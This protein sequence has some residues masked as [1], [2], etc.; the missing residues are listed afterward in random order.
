MTHTGSTHA[1][2]NSKTPSM[3]AVEL[4]YTWELTCPDTLLSLVNHTDNLEQE[5]IHHHTHA[6]TPIYAL[7]CPRK[8]T[9]SLS[10]C[11]VRRVVA[12]LLLQ[13]TETLERLERQ[14]SSQLVTTC[15]HTRVRGVQRRVTGAGN[16]SRLMA[17]TQVTRCCSSPFFSLH[18]QEKE[19]RA[20]PLG[21]ARNKHG[22]S[23]LQ[24]NWRV[25]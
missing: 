12:T 4:W 25:P 23:L 24:P 17:R 9:P 18:D 1:K 10:G 5:W 7:R 16:S 21:A 6:H 15:H 3:H 14:A 22:A 20:F 2:D 13:L 8:L 19:G 11:E